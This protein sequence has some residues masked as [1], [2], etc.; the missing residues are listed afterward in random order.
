MVDFGGLDQ[1][2]KA[3]PCVFGI[4]LQDDLYFLQVWFR[5]GHNLAC[6]WGCMCSDYLRK[7]Q[8]MVPQCFNEMA[9]RSRVEWSKM[10][11]Y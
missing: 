6:V 1:L 5:Y 9:K 4:W 2:F 7:K 11:T 8:T 10:E 3:M